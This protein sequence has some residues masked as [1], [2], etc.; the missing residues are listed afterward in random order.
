MDIGRFDTALDIGE[1]TDLIWRAAL[2]KKLIK[3]SNNGH[4][5]IRSIHSE[6]S[7]DRASAIDK[8]RYQFYQ[9]WHERIKSLP[10]S[11]DAQSRVTNAYYYYKWRASIPQS[12]WLYQS[13][14]YIKYQWSK[15]L[16]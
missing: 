2:H 5:V 10:I 3:L 14:G 7:R 1:D 6:H 15:G 9:I 11:D 4:S 16:N 13:L 8:A 12:S